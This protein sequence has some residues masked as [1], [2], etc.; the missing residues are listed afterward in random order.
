MDSRHYLVALLIIAPVIIVGVIFN[1]VNSKWSK[2][3]GLMK[4]LCLYW[5]YPNILKIGSCLYEKNHPTQVRRLF[6]GG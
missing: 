2:G 3:K 1:L 5:I 6:P 4:T